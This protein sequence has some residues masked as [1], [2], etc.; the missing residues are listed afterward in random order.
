MSQELMTILVLLCAVLLGAIIGWLGAKLRYRNNT[1][2]DSDLENN[3]V[4]KEVFGQL[5]EQADLQREDLRERENDF[6]GAEKKLSAAGEEIRF[7]R[8]K[9]ETQEQD[10]QKLQV[11]SEQ[12]FEN[13]ANRLLEEKS[14]RFSKQNQKQLQETLQPLREKITEFELGIARKFNEEA[15]DK[16]ALK[17]QIRQLAELNNQLSTDAKNLAT[18]LKGDNKTQGDWG[19][20]QLETL[21]E[22]A[23]LQKGIHFETQ[24]SY[25]DFEGREKRPDFVINLPEGKHLIIDSKVSLRAYEQYYNADTEEAQ[26]QFLKRHV[27]SLRSH[28]KDL[29]SKNYQQL[30]QINS[31]DYLLLFVPIE[32]AFS[33]AVKEDSR[34][35]SEALDRNIVMVTTS[36]LLATMRTVSYIWK[37][38]RQKKNVIEIARQSGLLYDRFVAFVDDL[39]AIGHK[40]DSAQNSYHDAMRK[41][42]HGKRYGNTLIGRAEKIKALGAKAGKSLPEELLEEE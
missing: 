24:N 35:F 29:S 28:I 6:R 40:L 14:E 15:K 30:Y 19:E 37:Q 39:K 2:P 3:Y 38:E 20:L 9:L 7:L 4:R 27:D 34:L 42:K 16:S 17:E 31:P 10:F 13:I 12:K 25:K 33:S 11:Q 32:P 1:L 26:K 18:A 21:L 36:T 23:G 5:Q 22:K 8:E 41:L